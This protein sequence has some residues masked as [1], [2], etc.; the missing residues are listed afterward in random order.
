MRLLRYL[1]G[2]L[3]ACE[4]CSPPLCPAQC[5]SGGCS[6]AGAVRT[7]PP[8]P[9][10]VVAPRYEWRTHANDPGRRY[11]YANGHQ[12]GG[13]DRAQRY[14]RPF[15]GR[16]WGERA[17]SPVKPPSCQCGDTCDCTGET[18]ACV[19][20]TPALNFGV[21]A[22]RIFPGHHSI[23]GREC[24][25]DAL[26]R[27]IR[28]ASVPDDAARLRATVIGSQ[29]DCDRVLSEI[30]ADLLAQ[31]SWQ[32]YR[33]GEWPVATGHRQDGKPTLYLQAPD[34]SVLSRTDAD[35][36][37]AALAVGLK[38]G[39]RRADPSYDPSKDPDLT[40]PLPV[41]PMPPPVGPSPAPGPAPQPVPTPPQASGVMPACCVAS[42]SAMIGLAVVACTK[43]RR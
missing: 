36:G 37:A 25:K 22:E 2:L 39:I 6:P 38:L 40:K 30:P 9:V 23:N 27:T 41:V 16:N 35:P 13:W 14:Y 31:V 10:T 33:P 12:V 1:A 15:D 20:E 17:E 42:L 5:G 43:R 21:E 29:A 28:E 19:V 18:C 24:S 11:L 8:L 3:L 4:S 34:G 32:S 7:Y 26:L